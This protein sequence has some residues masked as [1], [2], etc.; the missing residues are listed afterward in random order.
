MCACMRDCIT[1][2]RVRACSYVGV[3]AFACA[4]GCAY[5][6]VRIYICIC[7]CVYVRGC[8]HACVYVCGYVYMQHAG[9][10]NTRVHMC[11]C[12]CVC[13]VIVCMVMCTW[14]V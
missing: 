8:V 6:C 3:R 1:C 9:V 11:V 7:V 10:R 14:Y 2:V 5:A 12:A 13:N 4:C